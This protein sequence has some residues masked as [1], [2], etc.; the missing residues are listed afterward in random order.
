MSEVFCKNCKYREVL[1]CCELGCPPDRCGSPR[2][3]R[4][5]VSYGEPDPIYGR[6]KYGGDYEDVLCKDRNANFDCD[7]FRSRKGKKGK[8]HDSK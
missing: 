8:A 3:T 6:L 7:W 4:T 5:P 1:P 2:R